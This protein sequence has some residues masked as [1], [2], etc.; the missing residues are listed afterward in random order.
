M[1]VAA[2]ERVLPGGSATGE[3]VGEADGDGRGAGDGELD[4]AG[5]A[6]EWGPP[7]LRP[8]PMTAWWWPGWAARW[9]PG[10]GAAPAAAPVRCWTRG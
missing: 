8:A 6:A 5:R 1:V 9:R 3:G 4:G 2:G 7:G 10:P